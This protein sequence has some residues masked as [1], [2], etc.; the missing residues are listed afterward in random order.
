MQH[1]LVSMMKDKAYNLSRGSQLETYRTP[2]PPEVSGFSVT[3]S[4]DLSTF[5]LRRPRFFEML[6]CC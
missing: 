5:M 1:L 2:K 4:S 6:I 3:M